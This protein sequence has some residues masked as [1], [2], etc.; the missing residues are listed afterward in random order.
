[1]VPDER[2]SRRDVESR[3]QQRAARAIARRH[4]FRYLAVATLLVSTGAGVLVWLIDRRDFPTLEDGLW[5]AIVTLAT[6]GYGDIVPTSTW[7]RLIG[8]LVIV[9]G[10]TFLS[11]LTAVVTSYFVAADQDLRAAEIEAARGAG[12]ESTDAKLDAIAERLAAIE[13]EL[14]RPEPPDRA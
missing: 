7:G 10:V 6:V 14:R 5:W 1:M 2:P 3:L 8:S 9:M 13:A 12:D 4:V 11:M